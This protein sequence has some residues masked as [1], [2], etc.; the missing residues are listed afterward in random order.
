MWDINLPSINYETRQEII[1]QSIREIQFA[2]DF[3]QGKTRQ[4]QVNEAMYYGRKIATNDSRANVDLGQMSSFVHTLLSK[5]DSP[6]VFKFTKRKEAQLMRVNRLNALRM[7]DQQRDYWDIKD[8]A[9]KKQ[10]II[11]G[12]AIYAYYANSDS[13]KGYCPHLENVDV[14]D[15]L[16][17]PSAGG[18]NLETAS[19]LGR[20]GVVKYRSDIKRGIKDKIYLKTE[21]EQLLEGSGN[22]TAA[23]QEKTNQQPRTVDQNVWM[24][25]KNITNPDKFVFWEWYTTY[26]GERYYVLVSDTG[27]TAL[28]VE[29]LSDIFESNLWPFWTWAAFPDL[30]EFWTPSY[31]DYVREI[32]MAQA[33]SI[34]QMLDNSEQQN[35]PTQVIQVGAIENMA[36]L[37]YRKGGN[38]VKVKKE[39]DITKAVQE[40]RPPAITGPIEVFQLLDAIQEKA[41]GVTSGSKGVSDEDKVGIYEGNQANAADRFGLL[42]KSYAFGYK[43]FA[44]LYEAGVREHLTKKVAVDILGPNGVQIEEISRRDIFRKNE[45]FGITVEA[46]NAEEALS[47]V[48]KKNKIAFLNSQIDNQNMNH[49]KAFEIQAKIAGFNEDEIRQ[50]LDT[51]EFGDAELMSE[52]END[53]ELVMEGKNIPPNQAA[54]T[55]YKQRFVDYMLLNSDKITTEQ[56]LRL[57]KYVE[58]LQPIIDRNMVRQANEMLHKKALME[59]LAPEQPV[60]D[61]VTGKLPVNKAPSDQISPGSIPQ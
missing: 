36:E 57:A 18:L 7:Y 49:K 41:S 22:A 15:F 25:E 28:R 42:N 5:I 53:I 60:P 59:A 52:A 61:K 6:L 11:Y 8:I 27:G 16:V 40:L 24:P 50:L 32:F 3:K 45:T 58:S 13:Y 14:Y 35:K 55:A 44:T 2:R 48:D 34:N 47:E 26:E 54:N 30:T 10:A 9:G 19:Y 21:G 17:D 39:F 20:Y 12:R 29:K 23:T 33:V 51:S 4:W 43:Q 56:F 46:S 31:C 1:K 38:Q 37:K